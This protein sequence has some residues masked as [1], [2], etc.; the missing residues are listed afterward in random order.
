MTTERTGYINNLNTI[1]ELTTAGHQA[2]RDYWVVSEIVATVLGRHDCD[3]VAIVALEVALHDYFF[4]TMDAYD[5]EVN[6][7]LEEM[8]RT[9]NIMSE[10]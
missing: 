1:E 6:R 2:G 8:C 9:T 3:G 5:R 7:R 4:E 10:A